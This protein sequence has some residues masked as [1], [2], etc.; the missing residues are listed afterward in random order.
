MGYM[1]IDVI[2]KADRD[3]SDKIKKLG[4]D[5][6]FCIDNSH[7][8]DIDDTAPFKLKVYSEDNYAFVISKGRADIVTD[9]EK[10][11]FLLNKG[12][13][14]KLKENNMFVMFKLG[15][16]IEGEQ[17]YKV[18]KNLLINGRMCADYSVPALYVSFASSEKDIK[19]PLQLVAFAEQ[20]GYGYK[21]YKKAVDLLMKRK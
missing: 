12:L 4:F 8:R 18:Y 6:V 19:S 16:L 20:F 13:C 15:S 10:N 21:N 1:Y 2:P 14:S 11:S 5:S 9:L 3:L 17:F 7:L